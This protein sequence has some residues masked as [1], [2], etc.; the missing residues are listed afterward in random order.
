VTAAVRATGSVLQQARTWLRACRPHQWVKNVLTLVPLG[1]AHAW[2]DPTAVGHSLLAFA[3]FCLCASSAYLSNDI[4]DLAADRAHPRKR[5]RPFASGLLQP[6]AGRIAAVVLA[7]AACGIGLVLGGYFLVA[8]LLYYAT[9]VAYSLRLKR[10]AVLDVML[11]SGLYSIR[12]LAGA[13]AARVAP[14]FWLLAFSVFIF[15]SLALI[16]RC[17]EIRAAPRGENCRLAGRGY[18]PDDYPALYSLGAAAG[19]IAVLVLALYINSPEATTLYSHPHRL[20]A[21]CPLFLFWISRVWLLTSRGAMHDDPIV[22]AFR[23]RTSLLVG[24]IVLAAIGAA[25]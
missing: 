11:L 20:W 13:F 10:V 16:K 6:E 22:F 12:L 5:H 2:S 14:S 8:L 3:A 4:A 21:L 24:G 18:T 1:A 17:A 25:V 9:T 7:I 15:L 19:Y 23:D